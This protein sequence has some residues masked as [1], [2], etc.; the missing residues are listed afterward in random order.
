MKKRFLIFI[1]AMIVILTGCQVAKG[2]KN[3]IQNNDFL[4]IDLNG[5]KVKLSDYH[6]QKVYLKFW[7]S[8]CPICLGGLEDIQSLSH[9]QNDFVVLT[10]V[11]PDVNGEKSSEDFK[12]WFAGVETNDLAVL[13]DEDGEYTALLNIRGYPTS[14]FIDTKGEVAKIQPGHIDNENIHKIMNNI[15]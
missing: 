1:I 7:A 3:M 10:I 2:D 11:A 6:G 8:W 4:F 15:S 13:L 12:A 14:V 5:Q 9:E